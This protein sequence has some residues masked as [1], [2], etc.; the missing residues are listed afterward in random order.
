MS[1]KT[2]WRAVTSHESGLCIDGLIGPSLS[3]QGGFH[4]GQHRTSF[5][6]FVPVNH[7]FRWHVSCSCIEE[8]MQLYC[9]SFEPYSRHSRLDVVRVPSM[10]AFLWGRMTAHGR[11]REAQHK[12]L[13]VLSIEERMQ[14]QLAAILPMAQG[15]SSRRLKRSAKTMWRSCVATVATAR[16]HACPLSEEGSDETDLSNFKHCRMAALTVTTSPDQRLGP[17]NRCCPCGTP[18]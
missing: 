13:Q 16:V 14:L 7:D 1:G 18:T 2:P 4:S 17:E 9:G 15:G 10:F 5:S 8:A 6:A 11:C 3:R 12:Q